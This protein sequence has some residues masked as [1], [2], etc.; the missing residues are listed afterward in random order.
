MFA[1]MT[2]ALALS[3]AHSAR[4]ELL[5]RPICHGTRRE[6]LHLAAAGVLVAAPANRAL[7][8][9]NS[10]PLPETKSSKVPRKPGPVPT[11]IGVQTAT[12]TL[13]PCMDTKPHCFSTASIVDFDE[14]LFDQY[15]GDPGLLKPWTFTK[16]KED[17]MS[18]VMQ[19]VRAYP[20]GQDGID[21]GGWKIVSQKADYVYVQYE[22][23][24]KGFRDD[25][26]FLV[27]DDG[28]LS[29]RTSSR[30]GRQDKFVNSKRV[31]YYARALGALPGWSTQPVTAA[32]HPVYFEENGVP[33]TRNADLAKLRQAAE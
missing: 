32:T 1:S 15:V 13:R 19:A 16:S 26:E 30:I 2:L 4:R 29:L 17:A 9:D 25:M 23:L 18:D 6:L 22:S 12:G 14:L 10:L 27:S 11:D 31:N 3:P 21:G 8:F 5:H 24:I 33:Q 20:P 28:V 7:A